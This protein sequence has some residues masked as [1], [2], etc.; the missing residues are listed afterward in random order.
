M[1]NKSIIYGVEKVIVPMLVM[2]TPFVVTCQTLIVNGLVLAIDSGKD[3][4]Y[5]NI[6]HL[7]DNAV[8]DVEDESDIFSHH[9]DRQAITLPSEKYTTYIRPSVIIYK[10]ERQAESKP[11]PT[12]F[13][14]LPYKSPTTTGLYIK[15]NTGLKAYIGKIFKVLRVGSVRQI[16]HLSNPY[17]PKWGIGFH[18]GLN[19]FITQ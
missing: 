3:L 9:D 11:K 1:I 17:F 18:I 12:N 13:N 16:T 7:N 8:A 4:S 6:F 5:T 15:P 19:F 10:D 14:S 2:F